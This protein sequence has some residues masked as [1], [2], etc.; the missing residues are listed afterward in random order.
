MNFVRLLFVGVL[1]L[2][3]AG[4]GTFMA[5]SIARAPNRYP[6]WFAPHAPVTLAFSPQLLTNFTARFVTVGPPAARLCYRIIEPADYHL[7]VTSTNWWERRQKQYEFGFSATVPGCSNFWTRVPRGTVLLL[8]GYGEAQFSMVPWAL[9]LAQKGWRCVLVDLRGHGK[10]TGRR[11][12][13]GVKET[14]DLSQL[15]DTLAHDKELACPVAAVG[16]SYGAVLALRWKT[17]EPRVRSV[18]AIAPYGNL[19]NTVMNIRQDYADWIPKAMVRA[20]LAKLPS[21]LRIPA[22]EFDTT[23]VLERC[24]VKALFVAGGEDKIAPVKEVEL[25]RSLALPGS[26]LIV[27]P[28]ATHEALTYYFNDL[29]PAIQKWLMVDNCCPYIAGLHHGNLNRK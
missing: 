7:K 5:R 22:S 18:V 16:D 14:H 4:C 24:P 2:N 26:V 1:A 27:V 25:L 28:D 17:V 9:G 21:V 12:Y 6:S 11:I 20:G 15:L 3:T 13:F 23:T 19:S 8:H 10:S 29:F